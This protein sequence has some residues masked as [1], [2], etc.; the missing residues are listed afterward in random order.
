MLII[1]KHA[2]QVVNN[3]LPV[4]TEAS[5]TADGNGV[6]DLVYGY[7]DSVEDAS[8]EVDGIED[9][10]END[11]A[12]PANGDGLEDCLKKTCIVHGETGTE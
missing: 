7:E 3:V 1:H 4:T 2:L 6:Y 9:S 5:V 10:Q 11:K 8:E 12:E